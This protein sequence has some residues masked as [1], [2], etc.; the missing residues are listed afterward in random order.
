MLQIWKIRKH[1]SEGTETEKHQSRHNFFDFSLYELTYLGENPI[2][3][4]FIQTSESAPFKNFLRFLKLL[5]YVTVNNETFS[6]LR[7]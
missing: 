2:F 1:E 7:A 6:H 4:W 5:I 3:H